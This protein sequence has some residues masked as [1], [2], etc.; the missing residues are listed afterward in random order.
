MLLIPRLGIPKESTTFLQAHWLPVVGH[1][2][3]SH[4]HKDDTC[5]NVHV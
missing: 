5:A 1:I 4:K 2:L 3:K